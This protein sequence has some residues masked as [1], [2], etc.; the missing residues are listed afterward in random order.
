MN[1]QPYLLV[2]LALAALVSGASCVSKGDTNLTTNHTTPGGDDE[3]RAS[4]SGDSDRRDSGSLP[5]SARDANTDSVLE[6]DEADTEFVREGL[7][8]DQGGA[9]TDHRADAGA[10]HEEE[11]ATSSDA[12]SLAPDSQTDQSSD[13][14]APA[15]QARADDETPDSGAG[16][17]ASG[18]TSAEGTACFTVLD[19]Y[20]KPFDSCI[21]DHDAVPGFVPRSANCDDGGEYFASEPGT[22]LVPVQCGDLHG[23]VE[24]KIY[25]GY[26]NV[27]ASRL[28]GSFCTDPTPFVVSPAHSEVDLQD[29]LG[30]S[31]ATSC[32][33][34]FDY[35]DVRATDVVDRQLVC[36]GLSDC[37]PL[38]GR[39]LLVPLGE[40]GM[41]S[42]GRAIHLTFEGRF[43][44]MLP[45]ETVVVNVILQQTTEDDG[46]PASETP[47]F[48][49]LTVPILV[50]NAE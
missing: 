15:P 5:E 20:D 42:G 32:V 6:A 10:G 45:G 50:T 23:R 44:S 31:S 19:Q 2:G 43:D 41:S 4:R 28:V 21:F 34:S 35:E 29:H 18:A 13:A 16:A 33:T 22:F 12:V 37:N 8:E 14:A 30:F 39:E 38:D 48:Q 7:A 27:L 40:N 9:K 46:S 1:L 36:D 49:K 26:H 25:E 47:I 17:V 11:S 24:V 3:L